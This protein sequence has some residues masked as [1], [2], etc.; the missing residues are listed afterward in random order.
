MSVPAVLT[1]LSATEASNFP[2]GSETV[3]SG[4]D[5]YLR[6]IQT[7]VRGGLAHKGADISSDT[8]TDLGA[9]AGLFHDITGTTTITGFGTVSAGI[10]KA[11]QF[12]GTLILTHN[13][14]SLVLPGGQNITT[15]TGDVGIFAS[16][17][18][19]NWR[20]YAYF[21]TN[22]LHVF[23]TKSANTVYSGPTSGGA[24]LPAF[25]ALVEADIGSLIVNQGA[26]KTTSG[27]V[28]VNNTNANATLPGGTYGFYPQIKSDGS[29]AVQWHIGN[30]V[31]VSY[32]TNIR[33]DASGTSDIGYAQQRY[34]QASPPY[35]LGNGDIPLFVFALV[36]GLGVIKAT[37]T[38]PEPPWAYNGPTDIR[39]DYYRNGNG[40]QRKRPSL[41]QLKAGV[42]PTEEIEITHAIKNA[43]MDLI[44]HPFMFNDL[45]GLT[46]V[47]LDCICHL[48]EQMKMIHDCGESVSS[49][50]HG[51]QL[52]IDNT[53]LSATS[54]KGVKVCMGIW[55]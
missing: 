49:L 12:D 52:I 50:L 33:I 4:L 53:P 9:V 47:M 36:D 8:T 40:F 10:W 6:G 27:A 29:Q 14:T 15:A 21:R 44:P 26:L 1:D 17:G 25:R 11:L 2:S 42:V 41:A 7:A 30:T 20:C 13:A 19:G 51:G 18:S 28:S 55:K 39:P 34:I 3:G 35:N 24:A 45:T 22:G 46:V 23:G 31:G 32:V 43:D 54:P 16:E 37:Y 38:A 5:N 48:G